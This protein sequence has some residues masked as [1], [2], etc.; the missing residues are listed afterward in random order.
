MTDTDN[1]RPCS[2]ATLAVSIIALVLA[3]AVSAAASVMMLQSR[4]WF[5]KMFQ[6]M[7]IVLPVVTIFA[8]SPLFHCIIPALALVS[9][10]KEPLVRNKTLTTILNGFHLCL[11]PAIYTIYGQAMLMSLVQLMRDM[12]K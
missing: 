2:A 4:A 12:G 11:I 7:G 1:T 5:L 8:L 9:I 10:I 3:L 6:E